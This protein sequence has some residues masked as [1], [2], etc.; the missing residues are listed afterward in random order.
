ML[1][2]AFDVYG[3]LVDTSGISKALATHVGDDA[4][5]FASRWRDKQLE[6]SFRRGLMRRY[7]PFEQCTR[8]ALNY[9]CLE[10]ASNLTPTIRNTLMD[11]YAKLPLFADVKNT[12][13]A[14]AAANC[15]LFAFSNGAQTAVQDLLTVNDIAELFIDVISVEDVCLFKPAPEVYAHF[16]RRAHANANETWLVSG[17]NFDVLGASAA[18]W[19]TAWVRRDGETPDRWSDYAPTTVITDLHELPAAAGID[20]KD[21]L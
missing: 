14:L 4:T 16:L 2:F 19:R 18:G 15:K 20:N 9:V 6:Y 8:E 21:C 11:A 5:A 1:F 3:T 7:Q 10:R 17:N 12:L 13:T